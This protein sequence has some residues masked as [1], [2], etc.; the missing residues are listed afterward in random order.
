[1]ENFILKSPYS[2]VLF[3]CFILFKISISAIH[4]NP[5]K[6]PIIDINEGL[7]YFFINEA[8]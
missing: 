5:L 1:M 2:V 6:M 3:L 8:G 7:P 4:S